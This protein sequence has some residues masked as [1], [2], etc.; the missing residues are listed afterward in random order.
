VK[1]ADFENSIS[2]CRKAIE[3][4]PANNMELDK[5]PIYHNLDITY[6]QRN[7]LE[8]AIDTFLNTI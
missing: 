2:D 3:V 1:H 5:K 8:K 7:Q 4:D 6:G